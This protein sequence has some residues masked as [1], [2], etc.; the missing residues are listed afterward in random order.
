MVARDAGSTVGQPCGIRCSATG[1]VRWPPE[2]P[3]GMGHTVSNRRWFVDRHDGDG[4]TVT[5]AGGGSKTGAK[6]QALRRRLRGQQEP[7]SST[8]FA[9]REGRR[10]GGR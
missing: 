7:G 6:A 1:F 10:G 9:I 3:A 2:P 8:S 4:H 5:Q